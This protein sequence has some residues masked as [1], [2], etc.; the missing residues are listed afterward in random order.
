MSAATPRV[1][2]NPGPK[3]RVFPDPSSPRVFP[4]SAA[5]FDS[6]RPMIGF[7]RALPGFCYAGPIARVRSWLIKAR[8]HVSTRRSDSDAPQDP[9]AGF[10][11]LLP[12]HLP[13][14]SFSSCPHSPRRRA[15]WQARVAATLAAEWVL[16][17]LNFW[18]LACPKSAEDCAAGFGP[19]RVSSSQ[20]AAFTS[21]CG[22][23]LSLCR[24]GSD[25]GLGRGQQQLVTALSNLELASLH[26]RDPSPGTVRRH[27]RS[28]LPGSPCP[29]TLTTAIRPFG[30][31]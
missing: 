18:E 10:S 7:L 3:E 30:P 25:S 12:M 20:E 15:R 27:W 14:R 19:Y 1:P 8:L 11:D 17:G 28:I 26:V 4:K 24:P 9:E 29:A 31:S 5:V 22:S 21:L 13:S 16:A 23:M 6:D 2:P